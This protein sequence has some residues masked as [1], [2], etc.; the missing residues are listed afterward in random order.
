MRRKSSAQNLLS[1][2]KQGPP[3]IPPPLNLA[4]SGASNSTTLS[5]GSAITPTATTPLIRDN[6]DAQSLHSDSF[7]PTGAL[8]G[9]QSPPLGEVTTVQSMR[10]LMQKRIITLTYIRNIHEGRS[11]WFHTLFISHTEL[12]KVFNNTAM[13]K[14]TYRFAI[15]ALSLSTLLDI[16]QP[17]DLLRGLLNVV[18][19]YDQAKEEGDN[20]SKMVCLP[21]RIPA[22]SDKH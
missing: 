12:Q 10:A 22:C 16:N 8:A 7:G 14:R 4:A 21:S 13:K 6:W 5:F 18:S 15:L 17:Q 11:H 3:S 20:K 9:A 1:F 2:G 19:E